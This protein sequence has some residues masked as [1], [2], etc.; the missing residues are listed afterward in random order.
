VPARS[1]RG[2]GRCRCGG[3][4]LIALPVVVP[5]SRREVLVAA[6]GTFYLEAFVCRR[7]FCQRL[8]DVARKGNRLLGLGARVAVVAA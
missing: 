2:Y 3:L 8:V 5:F 4:A 6:V 1:H 7:G